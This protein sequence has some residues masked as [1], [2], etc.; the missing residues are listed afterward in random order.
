MIIQNLY[1]YINIY[2][3][4]YLIINNKIIII[5][6]YN[7]NNKSGTITNHNLYIS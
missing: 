1:I 5:L 2:F 3:H 6:I 4:I 7:N